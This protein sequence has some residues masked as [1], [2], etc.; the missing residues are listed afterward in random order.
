MAIQGGAMNTSQAFRK[1][2]ERN[3]LFVMPNAWCEGSA[4]LIQQLGYAS[5]ATPHA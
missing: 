4:R 2:H 5:L 1:L 3:E